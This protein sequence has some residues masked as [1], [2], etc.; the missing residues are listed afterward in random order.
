[1]AD[2]SVPLNAIPERYQSQLDQVKLRQAL[3]AALMKAGMTGQQGQMVGGRFVAPSALSYIAQLADTF[4][5][6]AVQ[7][8]ALRD[9]SGISA[10][11]QKDRSADFGKV[12]SQA[13]G[14]QQTQATPLDP[15]GNAGPAPVT[16]TG[17]APDE[18]GAINSALSSEFPQ[19]QALGK[20]LSDARMKR[21]EEGAKYSG[22]AGAVEAMKTGD[23]GK[24]AVG[25]NGPVETDMVPDGLGGKVPRS[26]MTDQ[27]GKIH[28]FQPPSSVTTNLG[29]SV[30]A[31]ILKDQAKGLQTSQT[32]AQATAL[33]IPKLADAYTTLTSLPMNN[34][35]FADQKTTIQKLGS[36]V[37]L[38]VPVEAA[39]SE[40]YKANIQPLI[41]QMLRATT[42]GQQVSD[43]DRK[44]AESALP[45]ITQDPRAAQAVIGTML[46]GSIASIGQH[47]DQV[48]SVQSSAPTIQGFDPKQLD[49]YRVKWAVNGTDPKVAAL[50]QQVAD[51]VPF[52]PGT[53]P[54]AAPPVV[55][56]PAAAGPA[57]L[58][59]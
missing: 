37:G 14:R 36:L 33:G 9:Q 23:I 57:T 38:D 42:G 31:D 28:L 48:G 58:S 53:T 21:L 5:G 30:G 55:A 16:Q 12:I 27:F 3:A 34:G 46:K 4:G 17:A 20:A 29:P 8:K 52:A 56:P 49:A 19:V 15:F 26:S 45:T 18:T 54:A 1:M 11:Y 32:A 47:N 51:G 13:S 24:L 35:Q 7:Q 10:Q 43:S 39:N 25:T 41:G 44:A 22:Q 50:M 6:L 40:Y 2:P 59:W